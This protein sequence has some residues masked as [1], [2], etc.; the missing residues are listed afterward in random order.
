MLL[1]LATAATS[2]IPDPEGSGKKSGRGAETIHKQ[3]HNDVI[4]NEMS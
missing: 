1:L 2:E 3:I 4:N